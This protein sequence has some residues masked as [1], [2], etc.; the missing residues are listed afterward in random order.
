MRRKILLQDFDQLNEENQY[1]IM[2]QCHTLLEAQ[3][4]KEKHLPK[5]GGQIIKLNPKKKPPKKP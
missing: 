5:V 4:L 2:S 1:I 3:R